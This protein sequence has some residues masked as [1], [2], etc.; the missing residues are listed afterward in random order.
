MVEPMEMMPPKEGLYPSLSKNDPSLNGSILEGTV[1][2]V[3][4]SEVSVTPSDTPRPSAPPLPSDSLPPE[5]KH[6]S[7][8]KPAPKKEPTGF[9]KAIYERPLA[10][11]KPSIYDA[12]LSSTSNIYDNPADAKRGDI[13]KNSLRPVSVDIYSSPFE[14]QRPSSIYDNPYD[15]KRLVRSVFL[16][17]LFFER[18]K[19]CLL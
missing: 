12:S 7:K 8:P 14:G 18:E 9:E 13:Y 11:G 2:G 5:N 1:I 16:Y 17:S 10:K 3:I 6:V 19:M 15:N 4:S